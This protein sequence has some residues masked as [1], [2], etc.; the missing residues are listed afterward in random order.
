MAGKE[1]RVRIIAGQW[2]GRK[3]AFPTVDGLRPT[4][5]PIRETLFSWLQAYLPS[6]HCLDLFAGS[7]ALGFEAASRG[8]SNVVLV[9]MDR[10]SVNFLQKNKTACQ[11]DN[12]QI[13]H[14][15]ALSY[16]AS[17]RNNIA[18]PFDVVFLDPPFRDDNLVDCVEILEQS[19]CLADDAI[20]YLECERKL[21]LDFIP[22][23]WQEH[24]SKIR[25]QVK[26]SLYKRETP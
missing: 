12:I 1:N 10:D 8:A 17:V 3:L 21:D 20:I 13:K 22:S 4:T 11:A 15:S 24:R 19:G 2:R 14:T 18:T 16:I 7:G 25:G 23:N 5:D 26:F 9:E 6:A